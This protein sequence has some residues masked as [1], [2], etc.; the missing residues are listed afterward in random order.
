MEKSK[1]YTPQ[2]EDFNIGFQYEEYQ[3]KEWN[4][5]IR[6]PKDLGYEWVTKTFNTSTSLS[7]IKSKIDKESIRVKYLDYDDILELGFTR[8]FSTRS[9]ILDSSCEIYISEEKNLMLGH[10]PN[11]NKVTIATRDFSK[12]NKLL[13]TNWDERQVN[14]ITI[15]NKNELQKLL[16]RLE[17][18]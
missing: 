13:K 9:E 7:K 8:E 14:L 1:Y 12:S 3:Q 11:L 6:P 4:K 5:I 17:N 18:D 16:K 10:Y 2:I 15:K